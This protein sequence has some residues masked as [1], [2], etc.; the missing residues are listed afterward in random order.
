MRLKCLPWTL[1]GGYRSLGLCVV[2][3]SVLLLSSCSTKEPTQLPVPVTAA[4]AQKGKSALIIVDMQNDFCP[5]GAVAVN[6]ADT[7]IPLINQLQDKVDLVVATQDWHPAN[8][9]SFSS[10]GA[11]GVWPVHCVQ[12]T[13]GAEL[14][15]RLNTERIARVF[16]KGKNPEIDGYSGFY[17]K[18][19]FT[20][21]GMGEYLRAQGVTDVYIVGVATDDCVKHTA[22]DAI[23][24]QKLNTTLVRD[25][26]RGR[27]KEEGDV[28]EAI[29]MLIRAGVEVSESSEILSD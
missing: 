18:D 10:N 27:E 5:G 11:A 3:A 16:Q 12:D 17:D 1:G 14:V 15:T 9:S 21:T 28:Q 19:H 24:S 29:D 7:I 26:T 4:P 2:I 22:L 13:P 6:D 25:A 20:S 23:H 8:H